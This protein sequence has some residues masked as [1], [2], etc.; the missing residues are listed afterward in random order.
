M[1]IS[2]LSQ[3][4]FTKFYIDE[5]LENFTKFQKENYET[6]EKRSKIHDSE[7]IIGFI[8]GQKLV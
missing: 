3:I 7:G 4:F 8:S 1:K 2:F 6:D 5:M